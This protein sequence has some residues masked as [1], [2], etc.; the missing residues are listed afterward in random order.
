MGHQKYI[1]N[2]TVELAWRD[3]L[4]WGSWRKVEVL[5]PVPQRRGQGQNEALNRVGKR[6]KLLAGVLGRA[7]ARTLRL[8]AGR[9]ESLRL[10]PVRAGQLHASRTRNG[11]GVFHYGVDDNKPRLGRLIARVLQDAFQCAGQ[12]GGR[13]EC[14]DSGAA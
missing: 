4:T 1:V 12:S 8:V 5:V 2:A 6:F 13:S 9:P 14:L 11:L 3:G 10:L 7:E